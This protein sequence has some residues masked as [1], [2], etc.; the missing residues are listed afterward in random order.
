[1]ADVANHCVV[2]GIVTARYSSQRFPGKV[3]GDLQG[4]PMLAHTLDRLRSI[5]RV[6]H[7]LVATSTDRSDDAVAAFAHAAGFSCWRGPLE[8]VL[9]RILAAALA[10]QADA[11]VRISGDS[12]LL[13]PG[14]VSAAI[15]LFLRDQ[16]D[17][18][19][20]VFPRSFPKGQSVEVISRSA[21]ERLACEAQLAEDREHVTRY[22]YRHSDDFAIRNLVA[23]RPRPEIQ[24]S[25]DVPADLDRVAALLAASRWTDRFPTVEQLIDLVDLQAAAP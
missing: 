9:G 20:N 3:L 2:V 1:M 18:V 14:L 25:V 7:V 8:D 6:D 12:P 16:P 15:E 21:L 23:A 10:H 5:N 22:A 4:R 17:L 24:L 13:D 19:T 11:V